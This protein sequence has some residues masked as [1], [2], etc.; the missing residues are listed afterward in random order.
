M[1]KEVTAISNDD[2]D[3]RIK[4]KINVTVNS[5]GLFT[6]T[7]SKE[8][9]ELIKSYGVELKP[10]RTGRAGFFKSDTMA[11]LINQVHNVLKLC[12]EYKVVSITP[13]IR[14]N[15]KTACS[16]IMN[17]NEPVPNGY[18]VENYSYH[19]WKEGTIDN[20]GFDSTGCYGVNIYAKPYMKRVVEYGN[21]KQKIFYDHKEFEK[22]TY[23]GILGSFGG[24]NEFLQN[25]LY[26]MEGTENNAKF[27]VDMIKSI[28]IFNERLKGLLE[29]D[30]LEN[31]INSQ[32]RLDFMGNS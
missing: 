15:F 8:D 9:A 32:A 10:N 18:Y 22:D 28:C 16:Y 19:E 7:L 17:G 2:R 29:N 5:D 21:G 4:V 31:L 13:V 1:I 6:T 30:M 23:M 12:V 14:Y 25:H 3:T 27:F 20:R 24:M 11:D 26:E